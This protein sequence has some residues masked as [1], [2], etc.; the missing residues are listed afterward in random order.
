ML[1]GIIFFFLN[2]EKYKVEIKILLAAPVREEFTFSRV[3]L[4]S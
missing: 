1:V 3:G 2:R 4:E